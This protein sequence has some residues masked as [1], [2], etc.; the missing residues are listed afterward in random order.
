MAHYKSCGCTVQNDI[1]VMPCVKH[2][3]PRDPDAVQAEIVA[4]LSRTMTSLETE[5]T[6]MLL[7]ERNTAHGLLRKYGRH[8]PDCQFTPVCSCGWDE[9]F[10]TLE[11]K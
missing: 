2:S 9:V 11:G 5:F 6:R 3:R 4:I 7:T 1:I 8:L 10:R